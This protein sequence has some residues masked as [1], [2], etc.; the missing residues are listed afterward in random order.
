MTIG[1]GPIG[2]SAIS[3]GIVSGGGDVDGPILLPLRLEVQAAAVIVLPLR[4]AIG[5]T[6]EPIALP[7]RLQLIDDAY[8]G[9]LDGAGGW[10]SAPSGH[11]RPVVTLGGDDISDCLVGE[12]VVQHADNEARTAEF[13]FRPAAALQPMELLGRRVQVWFAQRGAAGEP[14]AAQLVF[15]GLVERPTINLQSSL[16]HCACHDQLQEVFVNTPRSWIDANVGGRWRAEVSGEPVDNWEYLQARLESV[17]K[18]IAL[19]EQQQP[20]VLP[21]RD[22]LALETVREADILEDSLS[23]DLP[24]RDELR[25]RVRCRLQYRFER[26]RGRGAVA[27]YFQPPAFFINAGQT[28]LWLTTAMVKES[29]E[30]VRGWDVQ[31]LRVENPL[32]ATYP[33]TVDPGDGFYTIPASVAPDLAVGF[34]LHASTLW[35]QSLTEDYAVDLVLPDLEEQLGQIGEEIGATM[36]VPFDVREW[37]VDPT[38]QPV[39]PVP[40]AG[41]VIQPWK[42]T[43]AQDV[44]RDEVLVTLLDRGWVRLWR[45]SRSGRVRFGLPL[46]PNLWLSHVVAVETAGLRARG[47]VI[48]IEHRMNAETGEA[49]TSVTLAV[50]LP[51]D[52]GVSHPSWAL[53]SAP[54]PDDV[55][56]AQAYSFEVGTF[57]GGELD[58]LP[59]NEDVMIGFST[60]RE[61]PPLLAENFYPHQLSIKAPDIEARDR[62]PVELLATAT[63]ATAIPT[64]LLELP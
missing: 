58:S 53:P 31:S 57:V 54:S 39:L 36:E 59:F 25:T 27:S 10:P 26:L 42:P 40:L 30:A 17:G 28:R 19:D 64:D 23:V 44:D 2:A 11:W 3:A 1:L 14:Q 24:S 18:S 29:A 5:A 45:A 61:R 22:G 20:R 60:N 38:V 63:I 6:G 16:I 51:G 12:I 15:T 7:L 9:G 13:E 43:G 46:R 62:D 33:L 48:E 49:L 8:L 47:K 35:T 50:G 4:L 34:E 41:D 56:G 32:P 21:W 37:G 55:R 52:E